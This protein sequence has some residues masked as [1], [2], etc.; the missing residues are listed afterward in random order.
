M[1]NV[2]VSFWSGYSLCIFTIVCLYICLPVIVNNI[3]MTSQAMVN[4]VVDATKVYRSTMLSSTQ[5][6]SFSLPQSLQLLPLFVLALL[7]N[8]STCMLCY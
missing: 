4:A 2:S 6:R 1:L 5:Q 3:F 8:V 7:K